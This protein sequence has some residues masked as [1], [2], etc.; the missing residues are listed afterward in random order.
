[1]DL[2]GI[3]GIAISG[4]IAKAENPHKTTMEFV[5]KMDIYSARPEKKDKAV[6]QGKEDK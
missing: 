2:E 4:S 5:E 3:H 6:K 1:M